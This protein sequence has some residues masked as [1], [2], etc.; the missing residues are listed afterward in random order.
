M[1]LTQKRIIMLCL[2][3]LGG[4][5]LW[6]LILSIQSVQTAF[7][8]YL[9]FLIVQGMIFGL[10]F[11]S[12]F[13]SFEGIVVSSRIKA[14]KGLLL[15]AVA[16]LA[17]GALGILL[18]QHFLF[19]AAEGV[20]KGWKTAEKTGLIIISGVSWAITGVFVSMIEGLRANSLRKLMAGLAGGITGGLLGGILLEA[21]R[22]S[23][24]EN[25][26]ALLGG[27]MLFGLSLS[28]F[29]TFFENSF[30][31]GSIKVLNGPLKDK[32][33]LLVKTRMSIGSDPKC[34]IVLADYANVKPLHAY[35]SIKKG[36]ITLTRADADA[37]LTVNDMT[38]AEKI[39]RREDVFSIG[40]AKFIYGIFV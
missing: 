13:G 21:I 31:W 34:D 30:S 36:K 28:A 16:G 8:N 32:E 24:P 3:A 4:A 33:Y 2:G 10:I 27:L 6:P 7:P 35:I 26:L 22:Q 19:S 17:A 15:G 14:L 23:N 37:K 11:G 40:N 38:E 12:I 1:S 39:L 18:G 5:M 25:S 20:I 9:V 29:Y